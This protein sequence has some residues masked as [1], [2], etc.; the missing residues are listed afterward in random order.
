MTQQS[1]LTDQELQENINRRQARDE[2]NRAQDQE[3]QERN[4]RA[5]ELLWPNGAP[6]R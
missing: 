1:G 4:D 3:R 6:R 5:T 2:W